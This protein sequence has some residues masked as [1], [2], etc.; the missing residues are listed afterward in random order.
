L[1]SRANDVAC[2]SDVHCVND[3]VPSAQWA[4]IT[5]L[6]ACICVANGEQ[7][8]YAEHNITFASAKTSLTEK[9][10]DINLFSLSICIKGLGLASFSFVPK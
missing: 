5:S 2:G 10:E 4:N 6:R 7:H 8:H 1:P 9:R 3:V